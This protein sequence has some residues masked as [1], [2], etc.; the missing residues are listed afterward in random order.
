MVA[1]QKT[2]D[3]FVLP[4]LVSAA[5]EIRDDRLTIKSDIFGLF[6]APFSIAN[7]LSF[8]EFES[9]D[10]IFDLIGCFWK[11]EVLR[12]FGVMFALWRLP[13]FHFHT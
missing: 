11:N 3:L 12:D 2:L 6:V 1:A 5:A 8:H 7:E 9:F 10:A 4:R 13:S